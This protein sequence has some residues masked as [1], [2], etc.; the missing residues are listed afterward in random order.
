MFHTLLSENDC[1]VG[2]LNNYL[3]DKK[4]ATVISYGIKKGNFNIPTIVLHNLSIEKNI[5]ENYALVEMKTEFYKLIFDFDFKESNQR[6]NNDSKHIEDI[7]YDIYI[8]KDIEIVDY[9]IS[10]INN[11][12]IE[13]FINPKIDYI[14]CDKNNGKG[15]HL[16][17]PNII[18]NKKI[19]TYIINKVYE[20]CN[21]DVKFNL[22]PKIWKKIVDSCVS[23]ANGLRLL[24]Y[25]INGN[26]YKPN[27]E[28]STFKLTKSRTLATKLT[29]IRTNEVECKPNLKIEINIENTNIPKCK[30]KYINNKKIYDVLDNEINHD[31]INM[32]DKKELII[33]LL[34]ILSIERLDDFNSWRKIICL[35]N[36]FGFK[37]EA[38]N[39]SKKSSKFDNN[40]LKIINGIFKQEIPLE[41][42]T[43]N[44]LIRWCKKDNFIKTAILLRETNKLPVIL[45]IN[46]TDD[47][48]LAGM[49]KKYDLIEKE[50]YISDN[51][52]KEIL[53]A[54]KNGKR[55]IGL[56]APTGSG[57]TTIIEKIINGF[58]K[59]QITNDY[60]ED[61]ILNDQRIISLVSRRSMIATH[62]KN[63]K[64]FG[65]ES[66]LEYPDFQEKY[67]SSIEHLEYY[68]MKDSYSIVILDEFNSLIK[69]FYSSTLNGKR[70]E[71]Y[72]KLCHVI[73]NAQLVLC[74]DATMTS[75]SYS[76]LG[77]NSS[78]FGGLYLYRNLF[79]NKLD[80]KM[81]IYQSNSKHENEKI[82]EF[83]K[84]FEESVKKKESLL[85]FS[86]SK[87]YTELIAHLVRRDTNDKYAMVFN[88]DYGQLEELDNCNTLFKNKCV[89]ASPKIIY[90]LDITIP[91]DKVYC[92]YKYT[93]EEKCMGA[94]EYHQQ[95]SRAR[96]C[97]EVILLDMNPYYETM[98]NYFITFNECVI[99]INKL[100]EQYKQDHSKSCK[101]F[102]VT[103]DLCSNLEYGNIKIDK[104]KSFSNIHYYKSWY[105]KLFSR[106]KIQLVVQL[107]KEAGY[108]IDYKKIIIDETLFDE[109]GNRI[110]KDAT[111]IG[112][113]KYEK[114][115]RSDL[116]DII[117]DNKPI[118][119]KYKRICDN[120]KELIKSRMTILG[121]EYTKELILN[122]KLFEAHI[123]KK[124]LYM[125]E[126]DYKK[127]KIDLTN[128]DIPNVVC[129]NILIQKIDGLFYLEKMLNIDRFKISK[130]KKSIDIK[131][132]KESLIKNI[133]KISSFNSYD[134]SVKKREKRMITKIES[135]NH[136]DQLQKFLA[137]CYNTFGKI[138]S[139]TVTKN[140]KRNIYSKFKKV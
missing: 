21:K 135:I 42:F 101:Q 33:K 30:K 96:D 111:F 89:I 27:I 16:Y 50:K 121:D 86:D 52:L 46:S 107:A 132:I 125:K 83:Y 66:Y 22:P 7:Y 118:N 113:I 103:N 26:Y 9:I 91:Y 92:I 108:I 84:L 104:T 119:K 53:K 127:L 131:I 59:M 64:G 100:F 25:H 60:T 37:E 73:N 133:D 114:D 87:G 126:N 23:S 78:F 18:V 6:D 97:K 41:H 81:T 138:I 67:I 48:L 44:T 2:E 117:M 1:K 29:L 79:Q 35:L 36:T 110:E 39:I 140:E 57:K 102:D 15:I 99:I 105:D 47:F 11:I 24:Y 124:Y 72:K 28:K 3:C 98:H 61:E 65:M 128:K 62:S 130:I 17:Y 71:C 85:I 70:L 80:V 45:E 93:N 5:L 106:N 115:I 63:F 88:K 137:D 77:S 109:K 112:A 32:E 34:D 122:D 13:T 75:M 76:F 12:L 94:L 129:Y 49:N 134:M 116:Y 14:Y 54:I 82:K 136:I 20:E 95:Y 38:I 4:D 40:T 139:Y 68:K 120:L 90:G 55:T 31:I 8:N 74:C 56:H 19:H 58:I 10:L 69:H 123:S 43:I 51:A